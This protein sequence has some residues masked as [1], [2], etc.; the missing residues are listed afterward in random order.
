MLPSGWLQLTG[1]AGYVCARD[2]RLGALLSRSQPREPG[3]DTAAAAAAAAA[4]GVR[5]GETA[6][7]AKTRALEAAAALRES[8]EADSD[9]DDG[10]EGEKARNAAEAA[11][12]GAGCADAAALLAHPSA[13]SLYEAH[14]AGG[15]LI[16]LD[17][18][19]TLLGARGRTGGA[20][21]A[22]A[23]TRDYGPAPERRR[24]NYAI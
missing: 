5:A 3:A 4:R 11:Y 13:W 14:S 10:D 6:E 19:C 7:E 12:V 15:L 21:G 2:P 18:A 8:L 16:A 20:H 1:G 23:P 9:E 24:P 17:L 22:R